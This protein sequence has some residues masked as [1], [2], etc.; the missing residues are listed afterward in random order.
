MKA[1]DFSEDKFLGG[2]IIAAQPSHGFRAGHDSV[3]LAAAVPATSGECVLELGSGSGV[4]SLCLVARVAGCEVLG[5]EI[6]PTLVALANEN[7]K[8]NKMD[9]RAR[10]IAGDARE[11]RWEGAPFDLVFF[12]PPFHPDTGQISPNSSRDRATRD[13]GDAVRSWTERALAVVKSGGTVTAI[14]RADRLDDFLQASGRA[15]VS[16]LPLLPSIGE[17]AKRVIVRIRKDDSAALFTAPGFTLHEDGRP[18][19][20]AEAVLRHAAALPLTR[21]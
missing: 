10:F 4:A 18:T 7:A 19:H 9:S 13:T 21:A 1:A 14:L 3:L 11:A 5:I 16:V 8:R 2:R 17:K 12:N 6:D 20:G 15:G